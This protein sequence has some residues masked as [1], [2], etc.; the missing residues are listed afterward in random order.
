M[1]GESNHYYSEKTRFLEQ[2]ILNLGYGKY[3]SNNEYGIPIIKKQDVENIELYSLIGFNYAMSCTDTKYKGVHFF[4]HDYQFE[5]VWNYPQRYIDTLKKFDFVLS[6][7]F[8]PYADSPK[9]IQIFNVY[10]NRWMG[11][12]WQEQGIKVIPTV[13]FNTDKESLKYCLDGIEEGSIIAVSTM[14]EGRWGEYRSLTDNWNY[15]LTTLKPS[16][17]LLYGK[18]LDL[19]GN[20]IHMPYTGMNNSLRKD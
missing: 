9:A 20:I 2:N 14:G 11:R 3:E 19:N 16:K 15:L 6:P 12:F 5:R 1:K 10:R 13:T 7:D 4:L 8:S 17:V 18:R